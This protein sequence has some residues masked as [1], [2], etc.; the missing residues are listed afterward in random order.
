M[1]PE[2]IYNERKN[3]FLKIGRNDGF[4]SN[5]E[6][7]SSLKTK[8]DFIEKIFVNK[9]NLSI[10]IGDNLSYINFIIYFFIELHS[11]VYISF[12]THKSMV[13]FFSFFFQ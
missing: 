13:H 11:N 4:I 2:E 6:D 10:L 5:L 12:Q 8:K 1:S 3:K 9:K 7:L